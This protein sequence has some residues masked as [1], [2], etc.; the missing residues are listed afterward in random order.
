MPVSYNKEVGSR[1]V[2]AGAK[3]YGLSEVMS[4]RK[5][6]DLTTPGHDAVADEFRNELLNVGWE[7]TWPY[8]AAFCE[9]AWRKG[10]A[11]RPELDKV[12]K[13]LTP[14]CLLSFNNAAELGGNWTSKIPQVG[15]I[16][17][18][19]KGSSSS[20]HAFI[21]TRIEGNTLHTLEANT[22]PGVVDSAKDR[23]GDGVYFKTREL[24]FKPSTGLHLIGFIIPCT[25]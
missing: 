4:N 20:G 18:M 11:G 15:A 13:M 24:K 1:I 5:W 22:S 10:Y 12:R 9:V 14:G 19:R 8:C 3:F 17:I 16:G 2:A 21:V 25:A 6:D 7:P 23:E